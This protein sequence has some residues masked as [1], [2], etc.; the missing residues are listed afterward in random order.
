MRGEGGYSPGIEDYSPGME[1][2]YIPG[3]GICVEVYT[4]VAT[5]SVCK[6]GKG[7]VM[8]GGLSEGAH[9]VAGTWSNA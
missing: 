9:D 6:R 5:S 8:V 3:M 7:L 1:D 2:T 4:L